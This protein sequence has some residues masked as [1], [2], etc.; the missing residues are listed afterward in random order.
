MF[1]SF[2]MANLP[3]LLLV[4]LPVGVMA[5]MFHEVA[6]GWAA[7]RFGDP[8]ADMEGRLSLNPVKHLDPIGTL[9]IFLIGF[10]WAKPVPVN[11]R[12]FQRPSR[13]MMLVG[14]AGPAANIILA[15]ASALFLRGVIWAH[16][17]IAA[18]PAEATMALIQFFR[19][20]VVINVILAAF[21]LLPIPPL[22]GSRVVAHFLPHN[23][24]NRYR[25]LDRYGLLIV[26]AVIFVVP[27]V[28]GVNIVRIVANT[29][30]RIFQAIF[31]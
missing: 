22:D 2:S 11:P 10:G 17:N 1:G 27:W 6:H 20:G 9:M 26:V 30:L 4:V 18:M 28:T 8:T 5:V 29:A 15:I 13:D 7:R 3:Y 23:L 24:A 16:Y 19:F 14:L 31:L 25:E 21:N 12:Y